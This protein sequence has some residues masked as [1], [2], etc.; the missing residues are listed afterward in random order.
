M[1]VIAEDEISGT[2][3][4]TSSVWSWDMASFSRGEAAASISR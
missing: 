3:I 1:E 4:T 2:N